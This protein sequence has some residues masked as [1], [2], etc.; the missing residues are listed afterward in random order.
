MLQADPRGSSSS[1]LEISLPMV[2]K[3]NL[4][5]FHNNKELEIALKQVELETKGDNQLDQWS[6]PPTTSR[7]PM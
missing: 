3:G 1:Q 2:I 6:I 7:E 5:A 4:T